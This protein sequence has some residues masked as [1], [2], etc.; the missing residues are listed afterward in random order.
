M[1]LIHP[2]ETL[3]ELLEEREITYSD[4]A[5]KT[6]KSEKY[7]FDIISGKRNINETLA[8]MIANVLNGDASFWMNLQ[9]NYNAEKRRTIKM[10][11]PIESRFELMEKVQQYVT[12]SFYK[13]VFYN[14]TEDQKTKLLNIYA[15][16]KSNYDDLALLIY[17]NF[18]Q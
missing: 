16:T 3:K 18:I 11:Q 2:G 1:I 12:D 14:L 6:K 9:E 7:I 4:F 5:A 13:R 10:H 17:K 8:K 15:S